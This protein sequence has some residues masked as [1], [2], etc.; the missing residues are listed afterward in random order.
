MKPCLFCLLAWGRGSLGQ[1]V[2]PLQAQ[3]GSVSAVCMSMGQCVTE[4]LRL[5]QLCGV[6]NFNWDKC[7]QLSWAMPEKCFFFKRG[8]SLPTW[9]ELKSP[10]VPRAGVRVW[11]S[12]FLIL[13]KGTLLCYLQPF[14]SCRGDFKGLPLGGPLHWSWSV[15]VLK[16]N[17]LGLW[18]AGWWWM[19]PHNGPLFYS[20]P[21]ER[22]VGAE[23]R[24][25][26]KV[27]SLSPRLQLP[28]SH[29]CRMAEVQCFDE[30]SG[31]KDIL[32]GLQRQI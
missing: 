3:C 6:A 29:H 11:R 24:R 13:Q 9:G 16:L 1:A 27:H 5:K 25:K 7:E 20:K 23:L 17:N 32:Q 15:H 30:A 21:P 14:T 4:V 2:S 26:M 22:Q 10:N 19:L 28:P 8:S 12:Y 31:T 18:G